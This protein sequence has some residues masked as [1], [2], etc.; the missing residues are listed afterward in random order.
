LGAKVKD[1]K[2][3]NLTKINVE[4]LPSGMYLLTLLDIN[5]QKSVHKITIS[6]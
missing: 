1:V 6:H 2:A 4:N 3:Q 5:N